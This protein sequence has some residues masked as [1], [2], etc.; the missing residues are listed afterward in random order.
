MKYLKVIALFLFPMISL[1]VTHNGPV[2]ATVTHNPIQICPLYDQG[3]PIPQVVKGTEKCVLVE[4]PFAMEKDWKSIVNLH[5]TI[6]EAPVNGVIL[7][8]KWWLAV[9]NSWTTDPLLWNNVGRVLAPASADYEWNE[10]PKYNVLYF[11]IE[12]I[13][14]TGNLVPNIPGGLTGPQQV[15]TGI[16]TF[17]VTVTASYIL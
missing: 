15:K 2:T 10:Q 14:A 1:A 17:T 11:Q 4:I 6:T 7:K 3:C 12:K 16:A 13:D 9:F 8:G 5:T